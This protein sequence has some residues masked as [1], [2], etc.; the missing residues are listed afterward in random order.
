[1]SAAR[2]G[3]KYASPE[4]LATMACVP[5]TRYVVVHAA[6]PELALTLS[7]EQ[8][9][10]AVPESVKVIVPAS[11]AG[12]TVAVKVTAAPT[13]DGFA[14][15]ERLVVVAAAPGG[16]AIWKA[17]TRSPPE[18]NSRPPPALGEVKCSNVPRLAENLVAPVLG[19]SP[20]RRPLPGLAD[21]T[22]PPA[23]IGG[24]V[25]LELT[26]HPDTGAKVSVVVFSERAC[27]PF[28]HAT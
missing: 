24:P 6:R 12:L 8:P 11:G 3:A 10:I 21:H 7:A 27:T 17:V 19:S 26:V 14:E 22:R 5:A 15:E 13:L 1:V 16:A 28:E 18:M 25:A 2:D 20:Y 4:K 23:R 9:E